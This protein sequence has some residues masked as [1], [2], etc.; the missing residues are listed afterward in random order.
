MTRTTWQT[1]MP[2]C[3]GRGLVN[4]FL[5]Q[6]PLANTP[7]TPGTKVGSGSRDRTLVVKKQKSSEQNM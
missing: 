4:T 6:Q 2:I 7:Y 3:R 5:P 1:N